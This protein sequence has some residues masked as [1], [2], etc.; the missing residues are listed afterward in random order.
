[1][2]VQPQSG[3]MKPYK[4]DICCFSAKPAALRS[5]SKDFLAQNQDIVS[6]CGDKSI[7][8]L[9]FQWASTIRIQLSMLVKYKAHHHLIEN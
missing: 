2:R 8:R 5:K 1:M 9:L 6:E 7:R 4:I 3:Q